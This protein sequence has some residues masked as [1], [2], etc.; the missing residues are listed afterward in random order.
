MRFFLLLLFSLI[1]SNAQAE[2]SVFGNSSD[3]ET[4]EANE[5]VKEVE[6]EIQAKL[7]YQSYYE[8]PKKLFKGQVFTLTIK[9]LS[10]QKDYDSL[11]YNFSNEEGLTL[12]S[13]ERERKI[14]APYFY[15]TF[16]FRSQG[17]VSASLM[18]GPRLSSTVTAAVCKRPSKGRISIQLG[19]TL[20]ATFRRF[21]QR[22]SRYS[23]TRQAST[24]TSITSSSS[25]P[26]P[27]WPT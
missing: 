6:E 14:N 21:W 1:I 13:D 25:P 24:T 7:L 4:E 11:D 19:L 20:K 27:R 2:V 9:A 23:S 18:S 16:T 8:L 5:T 15:D 17:T 3:Q 26:K 10:A 22:T 12:L